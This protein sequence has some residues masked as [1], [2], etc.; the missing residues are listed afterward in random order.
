MHKKNREAKKA[1]QV[2]NPTFPA[3]RLRAK[4][5]GCPSVLP[6]W[7]PRDSHSRAGGKEGERGK[8]G[9]E[10]RNNQGEQKILKLP[11][12]QFLKYSVLA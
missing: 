11:K 6:A 8:E 7:M 1:I 9:E 5:T 10:N 2:Q 12:R 4:E 3:L